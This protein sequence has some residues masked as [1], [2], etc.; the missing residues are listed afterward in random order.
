LEKNPGERE[1]EIVMEQQQVPK[2]EA[3]VKTT[4]ALRSGMGIGI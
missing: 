2:E 1:R 4:R 3:A